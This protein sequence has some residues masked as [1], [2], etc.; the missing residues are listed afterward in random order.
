MWWWWCGRGG[1]GGGGGG[2]CVVCVIRVWL[3]CVWFLC[4]CYVRM[5]ILLRHSLDLSCLVV[6]LSPSKKQV[7]SE[8]SYSTDLSHLHTFVKLKLL[9]SSFLNSKI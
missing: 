5:C 3:V 8:P 4:G 9:L 2:V 6:S 1:G 7:P